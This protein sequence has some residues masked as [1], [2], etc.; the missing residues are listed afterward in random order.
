MAQGTRVRSITLFLFGGVSDIE[1]EPKSPSAEILTAVVGPVTSI[2]LGL[3]FLLAT[4][5]ITGASMETA[6]SAWEVFGG[7]G[8]LGTLFAWLGPINLAIG[9]FNLV[10]AFPLDGGRIVRAI[11]WA[12]ARDLRKATRGAA[13]I[14]GVIGWL[15]VAAG[16]GMSFGGY[17]PFFGTGI[18]SGLWLA[19]IGWFIAT[20]ANQASARMDLDEALAGMHVG[21]LMQRDIPTVSPNML[22]DAVVQDYL[23]RGS[24]RALAIVRDDQLLGLVCIADI[25]NVTPNQWSAIRVSDVMR[26]ADSLT[27]TA[28]ARPLSEAFEQM[29]RQDVDQLPVVANGKLVGMLRRRD[30]T[31]WLELAWRPGMARP[32]PEATGSGRPATR[33]PGSRGDQPVARPV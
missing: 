21:Q 13:F 28:P 20:A 32:R 10:P 2:L 26:P 15:F 31:R 6:N 27:T 8:P 14:G 29:V 17:V 22:L 7:L 11:L 4:S 24:D 1:R 3:A 23:V 12:I 30:V 16:V 19:F 9:L 25:R 18:G 33:A 5:G